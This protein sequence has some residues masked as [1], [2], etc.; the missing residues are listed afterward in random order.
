MMKITM[1][2]DTDLKRPGCVLLQAIMGGDSSKVS[3][4]FGPD[5]WLLAPTPGLRL[6]SGTEEEWKKAVQITN[7]EMARI[8]KEGKS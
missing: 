6:I 5:T 7:L 2:Y 3:Q 1:A 8:K 4:L